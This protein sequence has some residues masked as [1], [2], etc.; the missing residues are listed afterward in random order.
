MEDLDSKIIQ[1]VIKKNQLNL[2]LEAKRFSSGSINRVYNLGGKYAL[3]IETKGEHEILKPVPDTTAKLLVKGAKVPKIVDFGSV[4]DNRYILMEMIPGNNLVYDW[5][6]FSDKQKESFIEQLAEQLQIWHS[7]SCKEY[8]MPIVSFTSFSSLKPAVE[9]LVDKEIKLIDKTKL[10]KEI[11]GQ[12]DGLIEFYNKNIGI[13][14]ETGTAVMVHQDIHLENIFYEGDKLTGIIDLDWACEAPKDYELWKIMDT[15][16]RPQF[17][18]EEKIAHLY[19]DYQMTKE[20]GW[21]KKYYPALFQVPNLANRVR[22]YYLDPFLETL[23]DHQ[24][25]LWEGRAL[26]KALDKIPDFYQN[27]WLDEVLKI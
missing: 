21:L 8:S 26:K 1:S 19:G 10:P 16:H 4:K 5:M 18:V 27:S 3:K 2:S 20:L 11:A 17:T 6:S 22:L 23:I 25:G 12:I 14:D 9:R 7:I 15:F 24:N 13:L